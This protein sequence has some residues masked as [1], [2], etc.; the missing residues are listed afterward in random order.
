MKYFWWRNGMRRDDLRMQDQSARWKCRKR[1]KGMILTWWTCKVMQE[2]DVLLVEV[3]ERYENLRM[4]VDRGWGKKLCKWD[5]EVGLNVR[6]G[7]SYMSPWERCSPEN[8]LIPLSP[9][10]VKREANF[11]I[12]STSCS[13]WEVGHSHM[14][15]F[16]LCQLILIEWMDSVETLLW[17]PID[18][19]LGAG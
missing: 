4:Q 5:G 7:F 14:F 9:N 13:F 18:M 3:T 8:S 15:C 17:A 19:V 12:H 10:W 16:Y 1:M 6:R 2:I 11:T